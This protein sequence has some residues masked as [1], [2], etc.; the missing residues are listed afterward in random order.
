MSRWNQ[1]DCTASSPCE[2]CKKRYVGCHS[3]CKDYKVFRA[4]LDR[5][6]EQK[7]KIKDAENDFRVYK[8]EGIGKVLK[9]RRK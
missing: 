4:K 3:S 1:Y 5:E 9:R 8:N 2:F 7:R 6:N